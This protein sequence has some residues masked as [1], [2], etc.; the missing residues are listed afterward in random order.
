MDRLTT[1]GELVSYTGVCASIRE[2]RGLGRKGVGFRS[3]VMN[4]S[5]TLQNH[6]TVR[7]VVEGR[8]N[9]SV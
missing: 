1:N 5:F 8:N 3:I 4:N 7:K 2:V 6:D 9:V